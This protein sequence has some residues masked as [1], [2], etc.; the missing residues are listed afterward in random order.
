MEDKFPKESTG[1]TVQ[2]M[3]RLMYKTDKEGIIFAAG[4]S[5]TAHLEKLEKEGKVGRVTVNLPRMGV[6][7]ISDSEEQEGW[8][9]ITGTDEKA[10]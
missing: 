9:W 2:L 10:E 5:V 3:C 7:K 4:K 1:I 6:G 8:Q